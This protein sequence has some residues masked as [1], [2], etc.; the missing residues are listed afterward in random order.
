M[1]FVGFDGTVYD[2]FY[3]YDDLIKRRVKFVGNPDTRIKEDYLRILRYFRFYGKIADH[4]ACHDSKTLTIIRDNAMGL[5]RI[6]GERIWNETKKILQGNFA[7]ELLLQMIECGLAKS[8][9]LPEMPNKT[10]FARIWTNRH[11]FTDPL[12]PITLLTGLLHSPYDAAKLNDRLKFTIFERELCTFLT[13]SRDDTLDV[14]SLMTYQQ[15]CLNTI[16]KVT[17]RKLYVLELLK[18]QHKS[19]LHEQLKNWGI[20]KFPV[21]GNMLKQNG[22][23]SGK[24]IKTVIS[25]LKIIWAQQEFN[26]TAEDLLKYLP[27]ILTDVIVDIEP[28]NTKKKPKIG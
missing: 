9:A 24:V 14:N 25:R 2:Y 23:P 4:P 20:P 6:S 22:C 15:M 27:E 17:D 3:G 19:I 26:S 7:G 28:T 18:Y 11:S 10:E 13:Q 1:F 5:E 16:G 21:D 12:H 8:M